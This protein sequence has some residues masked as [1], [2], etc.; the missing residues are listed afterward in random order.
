M[1]KVFTTEQVAEI[2]QVSTN[3]VRS[4]IRKGTLKASRLQRRYRI[5]AESLNEFLSGDGKKTI[6]KE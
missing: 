6:E 2:L 3:T 1:Q 5:T 4:L